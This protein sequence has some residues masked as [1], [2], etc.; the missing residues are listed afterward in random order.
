MRPKT[1]DSN[2]WFDICFEF[3]FISFECASQRNWKLKTDHS[4]LLSKKGG[5]VRTRAFENT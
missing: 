3:S 2:R 4:K 5:S 1:R